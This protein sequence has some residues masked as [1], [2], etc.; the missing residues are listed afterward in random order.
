MSDPAGLLMSVRGEARRMVAPDYAE[1]AVTI[2]AS[3][4][5]KA[6][7]ARAAAAAMDSLTAELG[8]LG[9][10]ALDAGT[11]SGPL[12]WSAQSMTTYAE[13]GRPPRSGLPGSV[14]PLDEQRVRI[15]PAPRHRDQTLGAGSVE[16]VE[17]A[18]RVPGG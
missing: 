17:P 11:G 15:G 3:R 12:T 13:R 2:A 1:V 14:C 16:L 9:G 5:S 8:A 6:E 10:A 7:A 4:G 18:G